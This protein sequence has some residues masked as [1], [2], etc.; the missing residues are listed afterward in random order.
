MAELKRPLTTE[1]S[2]ISDASVERLAADPP[3]A[4]SRVAAAPGIVTELLDRLHR[5]E[6]AYCRWRGNEHLQAEGDVT[7]GLDILVDRPDSLRMA[8]ILAEA[9]FKRVVTAFLPDPA[10]EHHY[11]ALEEDAGSIV[12]VH[13]R[14]NLV[15]GDEQVS[16]Y[17]VPW[18]P[19]VLSTRR[20]D[21]QAGMF[22]ADPS[23]EF[24][25]LLIRVSLD[26][27]LGS[28]VRHRLGT[29]WC[30]PTRLRDVHARLQGDAG[31]V[32]DLS[33]CLLG[34]AA[35][36]VVSDIVTGG[37]SFTK[38]VELRRC[39]APTLNR[40]RLY[41]RGPS[42][43]AR[44]LF[45][46]LARTAGLEGRMVPNGGV[47]IAFL[48]CDGSGKSTLLEETLAWLSGS[49]RAVPIY[50]GSGVGP[51]SVLRWPL[52]QAERLLRK[53][54]RPERDRPW[55]RSTGQPASLRGRLSRAFWAA[56]RLV[57]AVALAYEKRGKLHA[58]T[59]ARNYGLV[60]V[61]DRYPQNQ[62]QDFNDG[63][64]LGSWRDHPW[65][66]LRALAAWEG[67][68][69]RWAEHIVPDLVLKLHV[70]ASVAQQRKPDMQ[71]PELERRAEAI[72]SLRFPGVTETVDI[73]A[74]EPLEQ[75]ARRIRRCIWRKL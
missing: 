22:V 66:P 65:R 71:L 30:C 53:R 28:R 74:E 70:R 46:G 7:R 64:M 48:G 60:V 62:F 4:G 21:R 9:G 44:A 8:A 61:C 35:G 69:Y 72:R 58:L 2:A 45:R 23:V 59:R 18:E 24:L 49:L 34:T 20:L 33:R 15:I 12:H 54:M 16:E 6:I 17:R 11:L 27:R 73:D 47:A 52:L 5:Q 3:R 13:L 39:V 57:W 51:S 68:P 25:F 56:A 31:P 19:L 41:R 32:A 1:S 67:T 10:G 37:P 29:P 43:V 38:V 14:Y 40:Y 50:F 42:L 55:R 36:D 26:L 63:P 75:V